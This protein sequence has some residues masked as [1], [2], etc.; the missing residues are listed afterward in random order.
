MEPR[1][2]RKVALLDLTGAEAGAALEGVTRIVDVAAILVPESL[3]PKLSSIALEHVAATIPIPDGQRAR[4]Y[5]G[6]V[7]MA[8]EALAASEDGS[9]DTLVIT[10]QLILTSPVTDVGRDVIVLGQVVAPA[11]SEVG[12]GKALRRLSGQAMYYPY[13]AG[14]RVFA[15]DGGQMPGEALANLGGQPDDLPLITSSLVLTSKPENVGY[16]TVVVLGNV[17]VPR[18]GEAALYGRVLPQGGRIIAYDAPV[19][20]FDGVYSLGAV[21]SEMLQEPITLVIDGKCTIEDDVTPELV[22]DKI[23]AFVFDGHLT[24]PRKVL[25]ALQAVALSLDGKLGTDDADN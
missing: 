25:G 23:R 24:A 16:A 22:R 2:I 20:V 7:T 13:T 4:V 6:Q 9:T 19:R 10:G 3:L 1:E 15:I 12:L 5:A 18:G 21:F 17:L 14:A 11:G 8:G